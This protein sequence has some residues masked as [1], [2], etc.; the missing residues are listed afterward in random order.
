[1]ALLTFRTRAW[2]GH[3]PTS[4]SVSTAS[5]TLP[6]S[7]LLHL[8]THVLSCV[9]ASASRSTFQAAVVSVVSPHSRRMHR[10]RAAHRLFGR[11][12]RHPLACFHFTCTIMYRFLTR[13]IRFHT[14][15]RRPK[16]TSTDVECEW[17][18]QCQV[19]G[20]SGVSSRRCGGWKGR[21]SAWTIA[22]SDEMD[23]RSGRRRAGRIRRDDMSSK[24]PTGWYRG[25]GGT[26]AWPCH[27][28]PTRVLSETCSRSGPSG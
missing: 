18:H 5:F 11:H 17:K 28:K 15:E 8:I 14:G 13:T 23:W 25:G 4:L 20:M 21:A 9:D 12:S 10:C 1:M 2:A 26:N 3:P 27:R 7:S 19:Q 22:F 16:S 6:Y 24:R